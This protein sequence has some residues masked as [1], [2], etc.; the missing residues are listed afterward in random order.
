VLQCSTSADCYWHNV[1]LGPSYG[2]VCWY[3]ICSPDD[4]LIPAD[5][6]GPCTVPGGGDGWCM[7]LFRDDGTSEPYGVCMEAG[8]IQ[9]GGACDTGQKAGDTAGLDPN[10]TWDTADRANVDVCDTGRCLY[11]YGDVQGMCYQFCNA[12]AVYDLVIYGTGTD[13]LPC[14]TDTNCFS[15][16]S[17]ETDPT[18]DGYGVVNGGSFCVETAEA[19]QG[20][21]TTCSVVTGELMDGSGSC[22]DIDAASICRMIYFDTSDWLINATLIGQCEIPTTAP[23]ASVGDTCT[24]TDECPEGTICVEEDVFS[25]AAGQTRCMP[26]CD[27]DHHTQPDCA[28]MGAVPTGNGTPMCDSMSEL[29]GTAGQEDVAPSR[30]GICAF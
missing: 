8:T 23:T 14:P 22:S 3:A 16:S 1:C 2:D 12:D 10:W 19:V 11:S 20:G 25:G 4:P 30:L 21:I 5:V 26:Y 15:Q 29:F 17:I 27:V 13:P 18:E 6:N 28:S 9:H 24:D 7:P